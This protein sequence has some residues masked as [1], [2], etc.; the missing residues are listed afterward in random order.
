MM[1]RP[2]AIW[3]KQRSQAPKRDG[4]VP[5]RHGHGRNR[6]MDLKP[7]AGWKRPAAVEASARTA[8]EEAAAQ[9]ELPK[10]RAQLESEPARAR[11]SKLERLQKILSQAGIASR[12][13]AEEMIVAGRVMVNGQVV[14]QLGSKADA[15]RDHIRV[16]GKLLQGAERHRYFRA[17]QA[18]GL[19]DDGERSRGPADGDG[20]LRE[21]AASGCIRWAGWTT[22]AK[23]CC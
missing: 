7:A 14:T 1:A 8:A 3:A 6:T 17:E 21:D 11:A 10:R 15:A 23:A 18:E 22:R 2:S 9:V 13:H 4:G 5:G 20:V 19:R 16:D 12:R